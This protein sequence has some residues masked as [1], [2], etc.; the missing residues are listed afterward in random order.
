[1]VD[2]FVLLD[3]ESETLSGTCRQAVQALI[4]D[5]RVS[6]EHFE[7]IERAFLASCAHGPSAH[8][9]HVAIL[10]AQYD[11]P[12]PELAILVRLKQP[13]TVGPGEEGEAW[14]IWLLLSETQTHSHTSA[15]AEFLHLNSDPETFARFLAAD[16]P[17]LLKSTYIDAVEEEIN[18][19][20]HIPEELR[21]TGR[22]FGGLIADIKRRLPHYASDFTDGLTPKSVASILF[23]YF[24]CLAPAVAFGGLLSLKTNGEIGV[25]E[26]I[27]A[28]TMCG[29]IYAL[30][31]GQ[32]LTI[33]GSTGPVI[34]FMGIL[35]SLCVSLSLAFLPA[36][37][38]VALWTMGF[39]IIFAVTDASSLIRYFTRF[40]DD[41]FAA[42]IALIF[43]YEAVFDVVH[44]FQDEHAS[45][46]TAL[47]SL[48]LAL[49]TFLIAMSL[50]RFRQSP[51][52]LGPVREFLADFGPAIA[53]ITMTA[54][55]LSFT[56]VPL[57]TLAVPDEVRTTSGRPW[58]V[59]IFAT[60]MW[61]RW[62]A[63]LPA[64]LVSILLY[65]DQNI[66]V[67]LVNNP[68]N[69]LKKGAG[70]HLDLAIVGVLVGICGLF[71]LPWMV[72][73]TVRSLN[74]VNSLAV[75]K[76][77]GDHE[78][79]E[80][81]VETRVTGLGVHLLVG[82]SLFLLPLL[83]R[84]PMSVLFGLFLFMG[85]AA[86][87]GNQFFE[88]T[89]LWIMDPARYPPSSY[90]RAVPTRII[91]IFT[92][93][94][95]ISLAVLWIVKTSSLGILFPLFIGMLVPVRMLM[96]RY[97]N[98]EHLALLDAEEEPE[99]ERDREGA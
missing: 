55:A 96:G 29:V 98:H 12:A 95:A 79:V 27:V 90:M 61:A 6:P 72:A 13:L 77:V 70:Y 87:S 56:S 14:F 19:S 93:I 66:T 22:L 65:L 18:F 28:T 75:K 17:T 69:R 92:A 83:A 78:V 36:A 47:L 99:Q 45:A 82:A 59:D 23:L 73:A 24:A 49:G 51:Y 67:R 86:M 15:A 54:L 5:G 50:K 33:L 52:L 25:I 63:A 21:S 4:E 89:R 3:I 53:I 81:V 1:M 38:W 76:T 34:I 31:S 2:I 7:T 11:T 10:S 20:A 43:I 97:F 37:A 84:V 68:A 91:H 46:A 71:G 48:N 8:G 88:R 64:V 60:P 41:T 58:L 32:P 44:V 39:L 94:Q 80:R 62:G 26:M 16:S 35:Y 30:T 42:L 74:H 57:E 85:I 40:T 9:H